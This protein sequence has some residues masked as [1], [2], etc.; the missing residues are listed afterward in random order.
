MCGAF[1]FVVMALS[2]PLLADGDWAVET[3]DQGV[4]NGRYSSLALDGAGHAHIS[5]LKRSAVESD[6][7]LMYTYEDGGEWHFETV[8]SS[9]DTGYDTTIKLDSSGYPHIVYRQYEPTRSL[10]Y[11]YRDAT[12]WH[13]E[14]VKASTGTRSDFAVA[15]D[16]D[17]HDRAHISFYQYS[18][19]GS[20]TLQYGYRSVTG[21]TFDEICDVDPSSDTAI[22]VD[23][24]G[25]VYVAFGSGAELC[26]LK[27]AYGTA[28]DWTIDTVDSASRVCRQVWLD[29]SGSGWPHIA[30]FDGSVVAGEGNND[31]HYAYKDASGWHTETV[32]TEGNT[33]W[34]ASI[35]VA[36][37][38]YPHIS[39]FHHD[40]SQ[41]KYAHKDSGGWHV[42]TADNG[43]Y[44]GWHS[45]MQL[46]AANVPHI[47]YY[48]WHVAYALKYAV[49][50]SG[51][52]AT[53]TVARGGAVGSYSSIAVEQDRSAHISYYCGIHGDLKHAWQSAGIW[54]VEIVDSTGDVGW[55]TSIALDGGQHPHI[56]YYDVTNSSLRYAYEDGPGWHTATIDSDGNVGMH[57]SIALDP[58]GNAHISYY[59]STHSSLKYAFEDS[60]GW[61][62]E[63]VDDAGS[64]G[65]YTSVALDASSCP[66]ISYYD[67]TNSSLKYAFEDS[68]G[69]HT[70]TVDTAASVGKYTS[71]ALDASGHAHVSYYDA[72][73]LDL[74]YAYQVAGG[75]QVETVDAR[76][77]VGM[78]TSLAIDPYGRRHISYFAY[79]GGDETVYDLKY[80]FWDGTQWS[81][82]YVETGCDAGRDSSIALDDLGGRHISSYH[83]GH[84]RLKYAYA[85]AIAPPST[86]AVFRT[87]WIG[88]ALCDGTLTAGAFSV[89]QG[90]VAEAVC[91]SEPVEP[92]DVLE[93][94]PNHPGQYRCSSASFSSLVAGAVS[95]APGVVLGQEREDGGRA[96]LALAGIVPVKVTDEGGPIQ[97]GDL[98][99]SSSTPG[100]AM[101]WSGCE[102]CACALVG[103]ALEP[104]MEES[105]VILVL[106]TAH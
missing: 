65:M 87:D 63:T 35:A 100:H 69:W 48:E 91:V 50:E 90:D 49:R 41:L 60:G 15:M 103:K 52:W 45:S 6:G 58:A 33:G 47:A 56:S 88:N 40:L 31:L 74:K 7:K 46:D 42:E 83:K 17:T 36:S 95:T 106:L 10:K 30:Y 76:P 67:S 78:E 28:A 22:G 97:P 102:H 11:S 51:V 73:A 64:V 9:Q 12:G 43:G 13:T 54:Q 27:C 89:G 70:E 92:G 21:W 101:R 8:D 23:G 32:D 85:P 98:L 4:D 44:V 93:H 94:D 82:E 5:Y 38:G 55:Y 61:H 24:S 75:W 25:T 57:T 26:D 96:L 18:E 79:R 77:E 19:G 99:V 59:D 2:L 72:T 53:E 84:S 68:G 86:G 80:A 1:A 105:G 81:T 16:L 20:W 34:Y 3:V 39:Y 37:D 14:V 71:I 62:T 104:M 66:H 29:L